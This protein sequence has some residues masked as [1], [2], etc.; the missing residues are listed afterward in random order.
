MY[1]PADLSPEMA[2]PLGL[3]APTPRLERDVLRPVDH[4]REIGRTAFVGVKPR[5]QRAMRSTDG[6][7]GSTRFKVEDPQS[8]LTQPSPPPPA[9]PGSLVGRLCVVLRRCGAHTAQWLGN[10]M[11]RWGL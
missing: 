3:S 4:R 10:P 1:D 2:R 11:P 9:G 7:L 5:N 8:L 6:L